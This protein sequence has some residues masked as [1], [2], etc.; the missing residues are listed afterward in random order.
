ETTPRTHSRG[1]Q[2]ALA[3]IPAY[4]DAMKDQEVICIDDAETDPRAADFYEQHLKPK[5]VS[6][7]LDAPIRYG[8]DVIG[9]LCHEH[10]GAPRRFTDDEA[11]TATFF[12]NLISLAYEFEDRQKAERANERNLAL[13]RAAFEATG[14]G[15]IAIDTE[16][17]VM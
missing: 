3:D 14:A 8:K 13:M 6:A 7:L 11:D 4:V 12:A 1:R 9:V 16:G 15:I 17:S 5:G 10:V 2:L